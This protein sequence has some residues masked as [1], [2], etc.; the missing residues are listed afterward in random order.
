MPII[1]A[2][3]RNPG[4]IAIPDNT[5][6]Y[7]FNPWEMGS[8]DGTT[9]AFFPLQ[10][11]G[12]NMSNGN[13]IDTGRCVTGY[14]NIGYVYGTSS[15]LF[16]Q[17]VLQF[18]TTVS[19]PHILENSIQDALNH[20]GQTNNGK[21]FHASPWMTIP[22]TRRIT[23]IASWKNPFVGIHPETNPN[24]NAAEL[25]LVD[26][27]EDGENIPLHPVIQPYREVDVIF[28]IDS[29]A[30]T[31]FFWPN[32]TSLVA[33]YERS[34]SSLQNKTNFPAIPDQNTFVNLG[35]NTRPTFFGCN[36][37]NG[38]LAGSTRPPPLI[39]YLPNAPYSFNS[40]VSTY[41][42]SYSDA[43]RDRI[44]TNG[45]NVA[46]RG[47][48]S[49]EMWPTCVGCAI[50]SRSFERTGTAIPAVCG[51]CMT[52]YCWNGQVNSTTPANYDPTLMVPA[53]AAAA[54]KSAASDVGAPSVGMLVVA[55]FAVFALMV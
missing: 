37:T 15:T 42:L 26:G 50:L 2:D 35:L 17:I 41:D 45:Y 13:V 28:A 14:D 1:I 46:T 33:T 6:I 55:A 11:I 32:G 52:D 7:E 10:Y 12:T 48:S 36:S 24:V 51:T 54:A 53:A 20:F 30:D 39:V 40:N 29:S 16:N 22:L 8:W 49:T 44:I 21:S 25:T 4:D 23:D 18:N 5:T 43:D 34:L 9:Y 38:T 47:N 31:T 19:L 3:S 27:G